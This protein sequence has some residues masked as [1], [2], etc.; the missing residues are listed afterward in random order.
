MDVY[1]TMLKPFVDSLT[2]LYE[3]VR[4]AKVRR[5]ND[6]AAY[7]EELASA[8]AH[9]LEGLRAR[10]VP[11]IPGRQMDELIRAFPERARGVLS[12]D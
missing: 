12:A 3:L 8:M 9:V 7:F 5:N 10:Q 2:N 6:A 4:K 1:V 11:R